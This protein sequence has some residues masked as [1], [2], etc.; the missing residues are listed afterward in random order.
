M[1]ALF[2][3]I[4]NMSIT[5]SVV[6]LAVMLVRIPLKKAPKIFSYVLWGVV[7]F[8]LICP[9]S[10]ESPI[11]FIP[12]ND[13]P[14][15]TPIRLDPVERSVIEDN[16]SFGSAL[17]AAYHAVGDALNGGLGSITVYTDSAPEG[18]RQAYHSEV[19]LIFGSYIWTFGI[20]VLLLY[21]VITYVRLKRRVYYATLVRDNVYETD[22]INTP[23][24]LGF[25]RPKIYM[26]LGIDPTQQEYI[27]C[28]EQTHIRRRDYLIKPFAFIILAL[29][30]FNP[31]IWV[32]YFLM[33]K[34]MEK[35]C[36]EAVLKKT[37]VDIRDIY[38][39]SLLN[40]SIK[41]T[42]LLSPLA[43]GESDVKS[44]VKNVLDF[45]KPSRVV[46]VAAIALVVVLSIGFALNPTMLN[47]GGG[48]NGA[49]MLNTK[50]R[51]IE[52]YS[53]RSVLVEI[54]AELG[55]T[56]REELALTERT[57]NNQFLVGEKVQADFNGDVELLQNLIAGEIVIIG[58]GNTAR[59]DFS[60]EPY[61]AQCYDIWREQDF[62]SSEVR[63][64]ALGYT[65]T[66]IIQKNNEGQTTYSMYSSNAHSMTAS[67][68]P[69]LFFNAID[70]LIAALSAYPH[71]SI[72]NVNVQHSI[73]FSKEEIQAISEKFIIPSENY[74]MAIGLYEIS[75]ESLESIAFEIIERNLDIITSSPAYHSSITPY[76]QAHQAEYDEIVALGDFAL[77]YMIAQFEKGGQT[78][79]R[80]WIMAFACR[81]IIGGELVF[82]YSAAG[83]GQEW[84]DEN[85]E[86][87]MAIYYPER[88]T[89]DARIIYDPD[90]NGDP[91]KGS[92]SFVDIAPEES[93]QS[94]IT[95][96][97]EST[98]A[99]SPNAVMPKAVLSF[100]ITWTNSGN[101]IELGLLNANDDSV[102][103]SV[104]L[105]GGSASGELR[106][107]D[108]QGGEYYVV[109]TNKGTGLY[110][111]NITGA[112]SYSLTE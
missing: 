59:I 99:V 87:I 85:K 84:Y 14:I 112:I 30:W 66:I 47:S 15:Q 39:S 31:I 28:H 38:S 36:D 92:F 40:L 48:I 64:G 96:K 25:I 58:R 8:R 57:E 77:A 52:V 110:N 9:V 45:K 60:K 56:A 79:L 93:V 18:Y 22:K 75:V 73:D 2:I 41:K 13:D 6:A 91:K 29:H 103:Y 71:N 50:A 101:P 95:Y 90:T 42:S 34:D 97:I 19:W 82:K 68:V 80:G 16:V 35:S 49:L 1:T 72:T 107:L 62:Y 7:L 63:G 37:D 24:V 32:S 11:S 76:I 105:T 104:T 23:F 98:N 83:T 81:D 44:R 70:E 108:V 111:L 3:S 5:A 102:Y 109:L 74:S 106:V 88:T 53:P 54:I 26:P 4:L 61:V 100:E 43:F 67:S 65:V 94:N 86:L 20:T 89:N 69:Y 55:T 46:I 78:D 12:F 21:A 33:S 27:F 17:D 10:F 51:V